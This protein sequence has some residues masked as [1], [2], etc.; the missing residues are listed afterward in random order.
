MGNEN[1][2]DS[3]DACEEEEGT[4]ENILDYEDN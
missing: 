2:E 4:D 1:D 3:D